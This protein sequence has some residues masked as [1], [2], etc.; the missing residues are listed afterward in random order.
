MLHPAEFTGM[1]MLFLRK[2]IVFHHGNFELLSRQLA[3]WLCFGVLLHMDPMGLALTPEHP[4]HTR[5]AG[6]RGK[7]GSA[8]DWHHVSH[9][10]CIW[11]VSLCLVIS[12]GLAVWEFPPPSLCIQ[13]CGVSIPSMDVGLSL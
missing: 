7:G 8:A 2:S 13:E 1:R 3:G 5:P 4:T 6:G 9:S 12:Q 11:L 10:S